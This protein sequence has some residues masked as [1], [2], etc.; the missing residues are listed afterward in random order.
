M[1][2]N[3]ETQPNGKPVAQTWVEINANIELVLRGDDSGSTNL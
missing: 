3:K 2:Q 1:E